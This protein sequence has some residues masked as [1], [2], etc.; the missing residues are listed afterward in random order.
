MFFEKSVEFRN[1]FVGDCALQIQNSCKRT[2][3]QS[4]KPWHLPFQA[5]FSIIL[6]N[7]WQSC[8]QGQKITEST[9]TSN[10]FQIEQG[11]QKAGETKKV[12]IMFNIIKRP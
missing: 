3:T 7:N 10:M 11:M 2:T 4:S 8:L 6:Q 1:F 12:Y 5:I 9:C